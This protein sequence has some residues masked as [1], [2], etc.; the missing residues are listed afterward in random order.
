MKSKIEKTN[1]K[2]EDTIT[3]RHEDKKGP[4]IKPHVQTSRIKNKKDAIKAF[5]EYSRRKERLMGLLNR[6]SSKKN[7]RKEN[8]S[9]IIQSLSEENEK[10]KGYIDDLG[11]IEEEKIRRYSSAPYGRMGKGSST[12]TRR[13]ANAKQE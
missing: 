4:T 1:K 8:I 2:L 6:V 9:K 3:L 5:G 12:I 11:L 13:L 7:T 10:A